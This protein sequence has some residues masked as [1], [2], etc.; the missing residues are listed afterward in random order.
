MRTAGRTATI[1]LALAAT[2]CRDE[3]PRDATPVAPPAAADARTSGSPAAEAAKPDALPPAHA[4]R[5]KE[6]LDS[7]RFDGVT[8]Y[9]AAG[10]PF[11]VLVQKDEEPIKR[12][13]ARYGERAAAAETRADEGLP[14]TFDAQP[15]VRW[16]DKPEAM[17]PRTATLLAEMDRRFRELFAERLKL[18]VLPDVGRVVPVVVLWD[19]S[20]FASVLAA[21][22]RTAAKSSEATLLPG[23]RE[24]VTHLGDE[25]LDSDDELACAE[26]RRQKLGDQRLLAAACDQL[27]RRYADALAGRDAAEEVGGRSNEPV[28]FAWGFATWLAA[29]ELPAE[30]T[31]SP[32][33][34]DVVHERI[35]LGHVADAREDDRRFEFWKIANLMKPRNRA[36]RMILGER[37]RPYGPRSAF[38]ARA[39]AFCHFLWNYADGKYRGRLVEFLGLYLAGQATSEKF[40]V[41]VMKR[42]SADDWGDV[43]KEYE[44]YWTKLL[45][46]KVGR[47]KVTRTWETPTT[48][49]PE[50]TVEE[51]EEFLAWWKESHGR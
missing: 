42:P 10:G 18:P 2:A 16:A 51:D 39:W 34:T 49:P 3:K 33:A 26:G 22:G 4:S 12:T 50:G 36:D 44:W 35:H 21:N 47:T 15:A 38:D 40:A 14:P 46:R 29:T 41:D 45:E 27:L 17:A 25:F 8:F 48:T 30:R 13:L 32:A 31:A 6:I 11:L 37:L 19:R 28:W 1:A 7:D 23:S 5:L 20:S 43:E 24:V 9:V